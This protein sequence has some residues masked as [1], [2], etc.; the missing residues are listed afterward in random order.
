MAGRLA[1]SALIAAQHEKLPVVQLL[2]EQRLGPQGHVL[3]LESFDL[4]L[5]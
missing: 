5:R 1:A 4:N 2:N 3:D